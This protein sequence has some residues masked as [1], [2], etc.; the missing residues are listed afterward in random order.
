MDCAFAG[1]VGHPAAS[2]A[3][4]LDILQTPLAFLCRKLCRKPWISASRKPFL[5][6]WKLLR[7]ENFKPNRC[8]AKQILKIELVGFGS[9]KFPTKGP[10]RAQLATYMSKLQRQPEGLPESSRLPIGAT[11][12]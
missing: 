10:N 12:T 2:A 5:P 3:G 11:R 9:T 4:V 1:G 7:D 8:H 6:A